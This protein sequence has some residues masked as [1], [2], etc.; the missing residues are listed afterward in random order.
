MDSTPED[1]L[2]TIKTLL[3]RL[4]SSLMDQNSKSTEIEDKLKEIARHSSSSFEIDDENS[5]RNSS[6]GATSSGGD[7]NTNAVGIN[8]ASLSSPSST[9]SSTTTSTT[10]NTTG[11]RD[12]T[13][14]VETLDPRDSEIHSL[15][16][17][18]LKLM[19]T[20]QTQEFFSK[21]Y[22]K[23][24][25][26][27]KELLISIKNSILNR[28]NYTAEL[29]MSNSK[30]FQDKTETTNREIELIS[31]YN[32]QYSLVFEK[33]MENLKLE[34]GEIIHVLENEVTDNQNSNQEL[35]QL[36]EK[37]KNLEIALNN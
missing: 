19:I 20:L 36:K 3:N 30:L 5:L 14:L 23:L 11:K 37:F 7:T 8:M 25:E 29:S 33:I 12:L 9:F 1:D 15:Q 35:A 10:T 21:N 2:V 16:S 13:T 32:K 17:E 6:A 4:A 24:L 18:N 28:K 31:K 34:T 22:E 27:N 26:D